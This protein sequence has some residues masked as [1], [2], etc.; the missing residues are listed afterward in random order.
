MCLRVIGGKEYNESSR[1]Y[2]ANLKSL[3]QILGRYGRDHRLIF[4]R[5]NFHTSYSDLRQAFSPRSNLGPARSQDSYHF[6]V[7]AR[8]GSRTRM[9]R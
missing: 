1:T 9:T 5:P 2:K 7:G 8:G 6:Q 3:A 4:I